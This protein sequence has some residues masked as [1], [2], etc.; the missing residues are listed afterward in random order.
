VLEGIRISRKGFPNRIIYADFLKRYYLLDADG[1]VWFCH[2]KKQTN[3]QTK[4][5]L[6]F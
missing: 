5:T 1:K 6:N 3:N 2:D 4:H